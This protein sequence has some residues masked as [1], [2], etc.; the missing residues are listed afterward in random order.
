[1]PMGVMKVYAYDESEFRVNSVTLYKVYD[2]DYNM[3]KKSP[4]HRR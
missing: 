4:F 1:M 2:R 3:E